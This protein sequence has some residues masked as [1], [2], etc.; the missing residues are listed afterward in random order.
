MLVEELL[1]DMPDALYDRFDKNN[2]GGDVFELGLAL[3]EDVGD[4]KDILLGRGKGGV[5][6][7]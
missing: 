2:F 7:L 4:G 3:L 1:T 6:V 5:D